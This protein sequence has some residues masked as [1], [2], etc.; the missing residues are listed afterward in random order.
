MTQKVQIHLMCGSQCSGRLLAR[1]DWGK[2]HSSQVPLHLMQV[3]SDLCRECSQCQ[4]LS[5]HYYVAVWTFRTQKSH[6]L[7]SLLGLALE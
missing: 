3:L 7:Q 2:A 6:V 4:R 5:L 1:S